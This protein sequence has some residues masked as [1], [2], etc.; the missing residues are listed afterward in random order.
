MHILISYQLMQLKRVFP[1]R[2]V[3]SDPHHSYVWLTSLSSSSWHVKKVVMTEM[4]WDF[5]VL[6]RR[7]GIIV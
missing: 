2:H 1:L 3:H 7:G 4:F 5:D 6:L